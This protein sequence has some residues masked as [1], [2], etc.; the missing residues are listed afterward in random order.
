VT[1]YAG[2]D[3]EG[4]LRSRDARIERFKQYQRRVREWINFG[5]IADWC[6]REEQSIVP[7]EE[8]R[9]SAYTA[10]A[11][12]LLAGEFEKNDGRSRVLYL[13]PLTAKARMTRQWLQDAITNNYDGAS[14]RQQYLPYCWIPRELFERWR[15]KH[16]LP[17]APHF[18]PHQTAMV[19]VAAKGVS[20]PNA[21]A[22]KQGAQPRERLKQQRRARREVDRAAQALNVLYPNGDFPAQDSVPNK[23][24]LDKINKSLA[25]M[26]PPLDPVKMDSALR[27]ANRR[28]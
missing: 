12:D 25:S 11:K 20:Q 2:E 26:K 5:E 22:E 3:R 7:N 24:L 18:Q 10:L 6:A 23:V 21:D 14:G 15:V 27:A 28:K 19:A 8:K 9:T 17:A 13:H 16:R 1:P 4:I